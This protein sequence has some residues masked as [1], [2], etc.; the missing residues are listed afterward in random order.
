MLLA[1]MRLIRHSSLVDHELPKFQNF[2][3][4]AP[5]F[6]NGV[7]MGRQNLDPVANPTTAVKDQY[8]STK[9][10]QQPSSSRSPI[11]SRC[12][13][14]TI[15]TCP[16]AAVAIPVLTYGLCC[17]LLVG[18]DRSGMESQPPVC[19]FPAIHGCS[20]LGR[21]TRSQVVWVRVT[22]T[23]CCCFT[24]SHLTLDMVP[25]D[26]VAPVWIRHVSK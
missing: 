3:P 17:I 25:I 22:N 20:W 16:S 11:Y 19:P 4:Q 1:R 15:M 23:P 2:M 7:P 6:Q 18:A 13:F 10:K 14:M 21:G 5:H 12:W 26:L 8:R 9:L 24:F